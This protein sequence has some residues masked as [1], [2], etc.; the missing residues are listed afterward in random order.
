MDV[1]IISA[2]NRDLKK[3]VG[4]GLFREDLYY[5][6]NVVPI[7]L[8]PLRDRKEDIMLLADHFLSTFNHKYGKNA[9]LSEWEKEGFLRYGWPGNIRE[10]RNIIE[11]FVVT[12]DENSSDLRRAR[13]SEP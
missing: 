10:L 1:R 5:R 2:T 7:F 11:R 9:V 8:P 6:L 4:E 12:G 3:M 13:Q